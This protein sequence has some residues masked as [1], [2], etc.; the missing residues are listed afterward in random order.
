[1]ELLVR[2]SLAKRLTGW[3]SY[4]LSRS[5]RQENFITPS[6]GDA[7]TTVPS[8]YDRT[9]VLNAVLAADLGRH[10]RAGARVVFYSGVPYSELA[11]NVPA[12]PYNAYRTA[13]RSSVWTCASKSAG[14]S[15]RTARS[16]SCWRGRT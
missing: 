15:A 6:G 3:V 10:W 12:P 2:R 13:R 14:R 8:D 16:L 4:T 5:R 9:H 11:G 7:L 1:M